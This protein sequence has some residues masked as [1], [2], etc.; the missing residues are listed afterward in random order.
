MI[1]RVTYDVTAMRQADIDDDFYTKNGRPT[2]LN[3][4]VK[5]IGG[6]HCLRMDVSRWLWSASARTEQVSGKYFVFQNASGS[7]HGPKVGKN[8]FPPCHV[9]L[10]RWRGQTQYNIYGAAL[11]ARPQRRSLRIKSC[12]IESLI[13]V[14]D[15]FFLALLENV[16]PLTPKRPAAVYIKFKGLSA[17]Y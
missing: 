12:F 13:A 6:G 1:L 11:D 10:L 17:E 15:R 8:R 5:S 16:V 3:V 7:R 9:M 14:W 4:S 2:F